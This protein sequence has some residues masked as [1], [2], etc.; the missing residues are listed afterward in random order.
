MSN[1]QRLDK[2]LSNLGYG[3][4]KE[5]K[6]LIKQGV[7]KVDGITAQDSGMHIC[8]DTSLIE[9]NGETI[10][11]KEFIY[12]MM[13][14][15][16][17]VI[18]ATHDEEFKTVIDLLDGR[19]GNIGLFPVGRLDIDTEGLMLITND[20]QTAHKLLSPKKQVPKKY[21]A[22][23]EG[24]VE[25]QDV[26]KFKEGITLDD[27]YKTFPAHLNILKSGARSEI[28]VTIYEGKY[29]QV[30]RMFEAVGKKV[31]YLRRLEMAA[32]KLDETLQPGEYRE[33]SHKEIEMLG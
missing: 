4:R 5:I 27:G 16:K 1:T 26:L 10:D 9:I 31:Q 33:L 7:I 13:N 3:S 25:N 19:L 12:I 23:I 8:P 24:H 30:K 20:G 21:Y 2:I 17:G 28:E 29:H 32:L 11:Y 22:L 14:K 18:S 6:G 15:P